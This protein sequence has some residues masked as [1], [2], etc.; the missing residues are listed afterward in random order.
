MAEIKDSGMRR[1]FDTG[2]VRDI[3]E[4][5]G[6]CDLLP[7]AEVASLMS[8]LVLTEIASFV[9]T[10]EVLY[11]YN[12][13]RVFRRSR[14]ESEAEM[15]L[16]VS[17][18]FEDGAKKYGAYNWQKGLPL[19]CYIDSGVRH[20]LKWLDGQEDERHDRAFVWNMLCAVW[21]KK[22]KPELDDIGRT[23]TLEEVK[24]ELGIETEAEPPRGKTYLDYYMETHPTADRQETIACC[25]VEMYGKCDCTSFKNCVEHW[26][27]VMPERTGGSDGTEE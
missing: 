26:N 16:E 1:E 7:L 5:K 11:L 8:D 17:V 24:K 19:S 3:C 2:A 6:R 10:H 14:Y 22:N 23:Y 21:T 25:C 4:G 13:L 9:Q 18:H 15:I 12:A 20:Y 27:S